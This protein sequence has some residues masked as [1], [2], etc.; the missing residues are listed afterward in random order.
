MKLNILPLKEEDYDEILCQWWKD[1]RW[2]PP[3]REFLPEN[4]MGGFIVYDGEI[5]IC[6]GFMYIT[7]S[8]ATWCDW[9]I[10]NLK[11]KD[12]QKRKEALELLIKT[13]SD[14]A[15]SLGK[16][17]IYAL[18]KN[19]PLVNVYKKIGFVEGSTYTHEMI[20]TI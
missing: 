7:N 10:S 6:A 14:K 2:T 19:K 1:W 3:S 9:I 11:Y 8:K 16:K 4:G 5:P 12:R 15:E 13:I 18:I 17:Y 20:K